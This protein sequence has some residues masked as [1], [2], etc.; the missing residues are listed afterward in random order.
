MPYL[1]SFPRLPNPLVIR[2]WKQ[3]A[4][5]YHQLAFNPNATGQYLPLLYEYTAN[6][7][8]GY[9]GPA[10][11]LPSYVGRPRDSGEGLTALGAVLGGTLAGSEHGLAQR[12]RPRSAVRGVLLRSSTAT[13]WS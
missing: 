2:D 11:G 7:A 8:A 12:Q 1:E 5:D 6:T 4:L 3:T 10:F 13:A 9:S